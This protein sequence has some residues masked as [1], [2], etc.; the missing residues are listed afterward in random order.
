MEKGR[1][2]PAIVMHSRKDGQLLVTGSL[3]CNTVQN[4]GEQTQ[5]LDLP[6]HENICHSVSCIHHVAY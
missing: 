1:W 3:S 6:Q 5:K 4:L 2:V